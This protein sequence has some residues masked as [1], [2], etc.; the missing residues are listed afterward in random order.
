[1]PLGALNLDMVNERIDQIP[2]REPA[3]LS[4][5]QSLVSFPTTVPISLGYILTSSQ[6]LGKKGG[7]AILKGTIGSC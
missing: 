1:M 3:L 2:R 7:G 6:L 4:H 5:T